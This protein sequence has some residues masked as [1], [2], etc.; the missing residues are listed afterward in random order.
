LFK[1]PTRLKNSLVHST[2][3]RE[4]TLKNDFD[5]DCREDEAPASSS[6]RRICSASQKWPPPAIVFVGTEEEDDDGP[7]KREIVFFGSIGIG[8][9]AIII[10]DVEDDVDGPIYC[11]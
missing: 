4:T 5:D 3:E 1:A 8:I 9:V 7:P 10:V 2:L 6:V 11:V